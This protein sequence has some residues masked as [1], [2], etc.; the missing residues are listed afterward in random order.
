LQGAW[1]RFLCFHFRF[2]AIGS[3]ILGAAAKLFEA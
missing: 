1:C 3:L 2:L